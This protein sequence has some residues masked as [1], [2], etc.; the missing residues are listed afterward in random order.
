MKKLVNI[1]LL[2]IYLLFSVGV[3]T[4]ATFCGKEVKSVEVMVAMQNSN[5]DCEC[6]CCGMCETACCTTQSV[7]N[8]ID[9]SQNIHSISKTTQE[10]VVLIESDIL[11]DSNNKLIK[12]KFNSLFELH[13]NEQKAYLLYSS[14]LI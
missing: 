1:F 14:F 12:K 5:S 13:S 4:S 2:T 7:T 10:T 6:S 8:K 11:T 9:D 3:T